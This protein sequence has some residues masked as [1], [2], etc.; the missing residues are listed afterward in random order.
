M[1][2]PN[3]ALSLLCP[4]MDPSIS[5]G[6]VAPPDLLRHCMLDPWRVVNLQ[7]LSL[8]VLSAL[9]VTVSQGLASSYVFSLRVLNPDSA[10]F[11]SLLQVWCLCTAT[12]PRNV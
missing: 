4:A 1:I 6:V 10:Y 2:R 3:A 12:I 8:A 5:F 7:L 11:I 9:S